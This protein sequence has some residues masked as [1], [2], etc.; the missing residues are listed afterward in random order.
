[1]CI[2]PYIHGEG[3]RFGSV[4]YIVYLQSFLN[5]IVG[6]A[7]NSMIDA[8]DAALSANPNLDNAVLQNLALILRYLKDILKLLNNCS[9]RVERNTGKNGGGQIKKK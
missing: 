8:I 3:F 5:S 9:G 2:L 6:A 4:S 7:A 1:M